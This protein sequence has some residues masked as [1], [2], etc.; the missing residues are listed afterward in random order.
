M[1]VQQVLNLIV[2]MLMVI[3][4][5][6][7]M[8]GM[9]ADE[10]LMFDEQLVVDMIVVVKEVN[11][12]VEQLV[13]VVDNTKIECCSLEESCMCWQPRQEDHDIFSSLDKLR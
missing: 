10:P 3:V 8:L 9:I 12:I 6:E 2:E 1:M 13:N 11:S 7:H 5:E 4:D